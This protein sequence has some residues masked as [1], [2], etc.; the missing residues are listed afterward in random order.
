MSGIAVQPCTELAYSF[1]NH[2]NLSDTTEFDP[3]EI[4]FQSSRLSEC[5]LMKLKCSDIEYNVQYFNSGS[6][7]NRVQDVLV[8][9]RSGCLSSDFTDRI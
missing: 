2:R 6:I 4:G 8:S 9:V 5:V 3:V 7:K 1:K